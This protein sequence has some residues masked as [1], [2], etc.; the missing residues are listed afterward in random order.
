M[1]KIAFLFLILTTVSITAIAQTK[2]I[3]SLESALKIATQDTTKLSIL[4]SL[5]YK[6]E[7]RNRLKSFDYAK[8]ALAL[9]QKLNA[10]KQTGDCLNTL[11]DLYWFSGD[12]TAAS[13]HYYRALTIF[14][15]I[16]D[17][18]GIADSYR[19]IG[20]IYQGQANYK[21]TLNYYNKSLAI[22]KKLNAKRKMMANYDDLGIAHKLMG[23]YDSAIKYCNITIELGKEI[24]Q[25][26]GLATGYG[27]LGSIYFEMGDYEKSIEN[28]KKSNAI[29]IRDKDYFNLAEGYNGIGQNYLELKN[30]DKTIENAQHAINVSIEHDYQ[31][32]IGT[33][34]YLLAK[35]YS[36]KRDFSQAFTY[37]EK[38]SI[39]TD[40]IY[41]EKNSRSINEM[42][43]K[44]ESDK[45]ELMIGSLEKD[46]ALSNEKLEQEKKFKIYLIVFCLMVAGF[47]FFLFRSNV[48]KKKT[49]NELSHAYKEI[50][51]KNKE[52]QD[53]I[54]YA[55]RIQEA[56][57]PEVSLLQKYFPEGFGLYMPKDVVSGDFYWFNELNENLYFAVADCT[58]HGVPGAF[59]SMISIDKLNQSLIDK[60]IDLPSKILS[61]VNN[62]IKN[63]LK[64]NNVQAGS[65]D[66]M[67]IALCSY[68]KR[69][70]TLNYAGANRPVWIIRNNDLIE[71]KPDK[72][73][74]AG[75]TE[76]D[77]QYTN[78]TIQLEKGDS[79]YVFTDGI[80]DQF[81]GP[82]GKKFMSK[83]LKELLIE[84]NTK[85]MSEQ[86]LVLKGAIEN[87]QGK[88]EQIDDILVLGMKI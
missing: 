57:L 23:Q 28:Y 48:E 70:M 46:K 43:A 42:S 41:N 67:D 68:D 83:R 56:M 72:L 85:P 35:A 8:Q 29:F 34:Y 88:L 32:S 63:A 55:K 2:K 65:K 22:N 7:N 71:Q 52:I 30:A 26:K 4:Q 49:N 27:N 84:I 24:S 76:Y 19:N 33:S 31:L 53:S 74:I 66:G 50:E 11:G 62:S 13:D 10:K 58:G 60:K 44:Y 25:S 6:L 59:M 12:Y 37:L 36:L 87:W 82:D 9:A 21:Q 73:S 17:E 64:Q 45:K 38:Y 61:N 86:E 14:E 16:K 47:A 69:T 18:A 20:W 1:K 39:I 3:D 80:V 77:Q 40:S 51:T 54:N 5:S 79:V 81:G 78:R 15:S 75:Y